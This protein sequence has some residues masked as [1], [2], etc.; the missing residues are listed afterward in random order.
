MIG[1]QPLSGGPVRGGRPPRQEPSG[2]QQMSPDT[3]GG[4][5]PRMLGGL[6]NPPHQP[7]ID[8][9]HPGGI[10]RP[11]HHQRI[12]PITDLV[13]GQIRSKPNPGTGAHLPTIGPSQQHLV[14]HATV[15][16][17]IRNREHLRRPGDI[18]KINVGEHGDYDTV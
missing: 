14:R 18:K 12:D 15:H 4:N 13:E 16:L 11:R 7:G 8:H 1:S 3:H 2:S 5:P 6:G 9:R 10:H 17:P